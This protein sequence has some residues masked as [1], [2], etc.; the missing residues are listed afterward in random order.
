VRKARRAKCELSQIN[1]ELNFSQRV[2][3]SKKIEGWKS[4]RCLQKMSADER[5]ETVQ[6]LC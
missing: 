1:T 4:R 6:F 2:G 5:Q 3:N